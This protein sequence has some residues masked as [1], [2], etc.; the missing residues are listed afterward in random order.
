MNDRVVVAG[1]RILIHFSLQLPDG[2]LID[3]TRGRRAASCVVGD[4]TL[5]ANFE[6]FLIGCKGGDKVDVLVPAE[7]AFGPRR[8][9]NVHRIRRER[10]PDIDLVPGLVV[11]FADPG[12]GELPGVVQ[13]LDGDLV[14]ID[15]N[16]PLAGRD[17]RFQVEILAVESDQVAPVRLL[18]DPWGD[19]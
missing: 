11:S 14:E 2:R 12:G 7:D 9:E 18:D 6:K 5:P 8:E 17:V 16:H 13:S 19:A 4:G 1:T 15:F 10:F 3:S